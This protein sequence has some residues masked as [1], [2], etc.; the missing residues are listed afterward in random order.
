MGCCPR[1]QSPS[2]VNKQA[3]D[4]WRK[5]RA[6]ANAHQLFASE[7][8]LLRISESVC[9]TSVD[10]LVWRFAVQCC[11][12]IWAIACPS[13]SCVWAISTLKQHS[14]MSHVLIP[15]TEG[16]SPSPCPVLV[17]PFLREL[18]R[19]RCLRQIQSW[20][21]AFRPLRAIG[22]T[23]GLLLLPNT[24]G[25]TIGSWGRRPLADSRLQFHFFPEVHEEVIRSWRAPF[26]ARNRVSAS[27]VLIALD[28]GAAMGYVEIPLSRARY[29]GAALPAERCRLVGNPHLLSRTC[30]LSFVSTAEA[31]RAV[32]QAALCPA[33]HG[34]PASLPG[35]GIE[36]ASR[37]QFWPCLMQELR[38]LTDLALQAMNVT[39]RVPRSD[40]VHSGCPG[41][42]TYGWT[43]QIWG[44]PTSTDSPISQAGSFGDAVDSLAQ[45]SAAQKRTEVIRQQA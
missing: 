39:K 33:C 35:Q 42:A 25:W 7:P 23:G 31:Y 15:D 17:T 28:G 21:Y 29:C 12:F 40:D 6:R 13:R 1:A 8:S 34:P 19:L 10:E 18:I 27:S 14:W 24:R 38:T 3:K 36:A 9:K 5:R 44:N 30:G 16:V 22:C 26:S 43:W 37:G 4:S 45:F 2:S 11:C 32:G 20:R 41:A